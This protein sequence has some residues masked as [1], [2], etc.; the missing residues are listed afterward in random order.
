MKADGDFQS[1]NSNELVHKSSF[2]SCTT[3]VSEVESRSTNIS[4]ENVSKSKRKYIRRK[5]DKV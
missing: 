1:M 2:N 3:N 5:T 4:A